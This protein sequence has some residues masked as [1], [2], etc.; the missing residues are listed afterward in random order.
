M[1]QKGQNQ[2]GDC[3]MLDEWLYNLSANL[4]KDLPIPSHVNTSRAYYRPK[5]NTNVILSIYF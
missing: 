5:H 2:N 3:L 1:C 4:D